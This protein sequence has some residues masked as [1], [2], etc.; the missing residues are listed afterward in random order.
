VWPGEEGVK[1]F[2]E[3]KSKRRQFRSETNPIPA[4]KGDFRRVDL[5][6]SDVGKNRG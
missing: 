6:Q 5:L 4:K 2:F 1:D 3:T